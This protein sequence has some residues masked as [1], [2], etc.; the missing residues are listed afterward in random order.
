MRREVAARE[1]RNDTARLLRE[2]QAG[3]EIVITSRGRPVATLTRSPQERR[4]WISPE[5]LTRALVRASAD[6]GLRDDLRRLAGDSTDDLP[7]VG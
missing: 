3:E 4:R 7:P 6:P 5:E 1:L 2:A